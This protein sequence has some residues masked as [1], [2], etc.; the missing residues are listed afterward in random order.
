V[1]ES[2]A[3][4]DGPTLAGPTPTLGPGST[5]EDVRRVQRTLNAAS[6]RHRLPVSGTLDTGTQ[7]A[8]VA[9]QSKNGIAAN[10]VVG[11]DSWA[12]LQAGN[13]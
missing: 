12:A 4:R 11:P 2:R 6:A 13:R 7:A 1:T 3:R 8:L 5:G 10:G 9:W